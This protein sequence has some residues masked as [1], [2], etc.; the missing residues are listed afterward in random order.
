MTHLG[1]EYENLRTLAEGQKKPGL[2]AET[3]KTRGSLAMPQRNFEQIL[4]FCFQYRKYRTDREVGFDIAGTVQRIES[5]SVAG[6]GIALVEAFTFLGG[7][8]GKRQIPQGVLVELVGKHVEGLLQVAVG[9]S[10]SAG[11]IEVDEIV[12]RD[13]ARQPGARIG[14]RRD[15]RSQFVAFCPTASPL[16]E[17][18]R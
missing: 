9:I 2:R 5:D 17:Y 14:D 6:I 8:K 1:I 16:L 15:D 13:N 4:R 11:G 10:D 12:A 3:D 18:S 7:D